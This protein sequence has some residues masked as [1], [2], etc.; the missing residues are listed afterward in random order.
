[1]GEAAFFAALKKQLENGLRLIQ[2]REKILQAQALVSFAEQVIA[3]AKPFGAQILINSDVALARKVG[4]DGVHFPS[5]TLMRLKE[6]PNG[7]MVAASCHNAVE[8]AHAQKLG[9][10]FAVLSPVRPTKSHESAETLGWQKFSQLI[11]SVE[12]PV[13]ALGGMTLDDL[14]QALTNGAR[15]IAMQRAIWAPLP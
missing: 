10:D 12:I 4:A 8:L 13:Y 7:L 11:K 3:M 9:L 1:M 14:P 15:G 6:K 2:I 5:D